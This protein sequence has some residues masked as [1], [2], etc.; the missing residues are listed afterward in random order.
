MK[1]FQTSKDNLDEVVFENRN[2][3]YGAYAI[4]KDYDANLTKATA[5]SFSLLLLFFSTVYVAYLFKSEPLPIPTPGGGKEIPV[6]AG[7]I[8]P[9]IEIVP[10]DF[11][12][13]A[14]T[15]SANNLNFRIVRDHLLQQQPQQPVVQPSQD[16]SSGGAQQGG[17]PGPDVGGTPGTG[18]PGG[19]GEGPGGGEPKEPEKEPEVIPTWVSEMP[20]FPG[21]LDQLREYFEKNLRYPN[22]ARELGIEGKVV[23][24]FV[25]TASGEITN[26]KLQKTIG[27]G[28]DDE[29]V[30]VVG[31]MPGWNPGKQAGKHVPVQMI[32]PVVFKLH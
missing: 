28:C 8:L 23:V 5:S 6:D 21:G 14:V 7:K 3:L 26:I 16:N 13:K 20:S 12:A 25:V 31:E 22:N 17:T 29:A 4:R 2:K 1:L 10:D 15:A 9:K 30:R 11:F 18:G 32:L 19:T 27:Y 24:T